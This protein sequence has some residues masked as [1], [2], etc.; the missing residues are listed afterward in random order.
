MKHPCFIHLSPTFQP[1]QATRD[2]LGGGLE[3]A[4]QQLEKCWFVLGYPEVMVYGIFL[5]YI[6]GGCD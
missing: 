3:S 2:H 1:S 5:I 6:I 4:S